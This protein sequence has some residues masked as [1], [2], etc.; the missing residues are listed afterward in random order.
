MVELKSIAAS[1]GRGES[2]ADAEHDERALRPEHAAAARLQSGTG[3]TDDRQQSH[4][5]R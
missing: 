4:V 1:A 5:R 2:D 3:R